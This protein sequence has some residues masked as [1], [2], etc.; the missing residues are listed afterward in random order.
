MTYRRLLR[1]LSWVA[2]VAAFVVILA[3]LKG[4]G[5][6]LSVPGIVVVIVLLGVSRLMIGRSRRRRRTRPITP[7]DR[8]R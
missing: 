3:V 1:I 4:A 6:P 8:P 2:P 7:R 5:V